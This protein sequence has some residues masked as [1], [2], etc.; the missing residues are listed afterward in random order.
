MDPMQRQAPEVSCGKLPRLVCPPPLDE[1]TLDDTSDGPAKPGAKSPLSH[2]V[3]SPFGSAGVDVVPMMAVLMNGGSATLGRLPSVD[4]F[5]G[6][7]SDFAEELEGGPSHRFEQS[8]SGVCFLAQCAL[9]TSCVNAIMVFTGLPGTVGGVMRSSTFEAVPIAV[10]ACQLLFAIS[11]WLFEMEL[12][13]VERFPVLTALQDAIVHII[14]CLAG[15]G[16]R[17]LF[18]TVQAS[19][20]L[21][22]FSADEPQHLV[23]SLWLTVVAFFH[24]CACFNLMPRHVITKTS[25]F[26]ADCRQAIGLDAEEVFVGTSSGNDPAA[27]TSVTSVSQ[28]SAAYPLRETSRELQ[29]VEATASRSAVQ[30]QDVEVQSDEEALMHEGL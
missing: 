17:S 15:V 10:A 12:S 8:Q 1:C 11:L 13:W 2:F 23:I 26:P 6:A 22:Y 24:V 5:S 20:W 14:P 19:V 18:Y 9:A 30:M 29:L 25:R 4:E 28:T 16:H 21:L 3:R 27:R 7:L